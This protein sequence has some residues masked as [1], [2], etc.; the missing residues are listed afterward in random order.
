MPV[1]SIKTPGQVQTSSTRELDNLLDTDGM[2]SLDSNGN[3]VEPARAATTTATASAG[4]IRYASN[5]LHIHDGTAERKIYNTTD[6]AVASG[7]ATL[8]GSTL[9]VQNPANATATPTASKIPIADGSGKLAAGWGGA[10]STLATLNSSVKV[11][12]DPANAQTTSAA[13]K[14]PLA[15]ANGDIANEWIRDDLMKYVA[16]PLTAQNILDMFGAPVQ[17]IAAPGANKAIIVHD[18]VFEMKR[19][20]TAFANGGAVSIEY[21]DGG[22][23]VVATIAATVITGAAGT[24]LSTRVMADLSDIALAS[25]E[26]SNLR[27]TNGTGAFITGTGTAEVHIW[28]SVIDVTA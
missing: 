25:I 22:D 2:A 28:Y 27:I 7:L 24:T 10:A 26:N 12:E 8:D 16:V 15:D 1:T 20:A 11:V 6:A 3:V 4:H 19:S 13:A 14:I 21:G 23:D 17:L 18:L 5:D 9:V